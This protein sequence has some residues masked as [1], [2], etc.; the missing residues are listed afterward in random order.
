MLTKE[1]NERLTRVG[2]GTP[3]GELLRRYWHPVCPAEDLTGEHPMKRVRLLA[4][5]LVLYR[6][7]DGGYGCVGEHC[8]HRGASLYYGF[9]EDG[10]IRCPYHGWL[11]DKTGACLE[12]P[13]EPGQSMM[14]HAIR[15]PAYPVEERA[16][17]LFIYMGPQPAPLVPNY[18]VMVRKDG[19]RRIELDPLLNCNWLQMMETNV[20][21]THN[22]FLHHYMSIKLNLG[23]RLELDPPMREIEFEAC[24]WGI[25]KRCLLADTAG[26]RWEESGTAIFPN[27][28]RHHLSRGN[29]SLHY[30]VPIDDTHSRTIWVGFDP[31]KDGREVD[32]TEIP[33]S[34][35]EFK[36]EN[37][38]FTMQNNGNQDSMAWETQ[39]PIR[40]RTIERL[41]AT[42]R[43][44]VLFRELLREQIE[45]VRGGD[46]PMGVVRDPDR[47]RI[48]RFAER[49][50]RV[51]EP[52][53]STR[54][55]ERQLL[56]GLA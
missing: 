25:M 10:G 2:P 13:F 21:P 49:R 12:Q 36:D 55:V 32:Q 42:D 46:E 51:G 30:R 39:G 1:E 28:L 54:P 44:V 29:M 15:H 45:V 9:L 34:Y 31:S 11:Y 5:D 22:H 33:V 20:D 53:V 52:T 38:D 35:N 23:R 41:G 16:R 3:G 43:G 6:D 24:E 56:S 17:L 19:T 27:V 8:S 50:E 7:P 40:D 14:R 26:D 47:N 18:D 4:E 48:I 37:G